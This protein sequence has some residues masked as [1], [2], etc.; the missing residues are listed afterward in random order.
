MCLPW[1]GPHRLDRRI[2]VSFNKYYLAPKNL[3]KSFDLVLVVATHALDG[4]EVRWASRHAAKKATGRFQKGSGA[5]KLLRWN[6]PS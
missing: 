3:K 2:F 4:R 6:L 5:S 1:M